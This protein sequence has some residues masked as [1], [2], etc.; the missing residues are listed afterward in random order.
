MPLYVPFFQQQPGTWPGGQVH[1]IFRD[2]LGS[3]YPNGN[4]RL[5]V[6]T[7]TIERPADY[8]H[9]ANAERLHIPLAG[10]GLRLHFRQPDETTELATG[11]SCT[12]SGERPLHAIPADGPVFAFNL[13]YRQ[14][15]IS[16]ARFVDVKAKRQALPLYAPPGADLTQIV[17]AVAGEFLVDG[18]GKSQLMRAGDTSIYRLTESAAATL[19][20]TG[21]T[22]DAS[23]LFAY[24]LTPVQSTTS[25]STT[26]HSTTSH[27]ATSS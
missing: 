21:R 11:E 15:Q 7:A 27:S 13:I 2:P 5:W 24:V 8:T 19:F 6:G 3:D 17:Y 22:P 25:R 10:R 16:G 9:F 26:S 14:G 1:E 23:L 12:F 4:Y 20:V 18:W